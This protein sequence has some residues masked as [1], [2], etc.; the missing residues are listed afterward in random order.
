MN[1]QK[2]VVLKQNKFQYLG[3]VKRGYI[4]TNYYN[5]LCKEIFEASAAL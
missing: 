4:N 3:H 1:K 2:E 5:W